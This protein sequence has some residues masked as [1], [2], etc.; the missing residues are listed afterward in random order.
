[1]SDFI[2]AREYLDANDVVI[3]NCDYQCNVLVMDDANFNNYRRGGRF[4]YYGGHYK[5]LPARISV[6]HSDHWN[7]VID[8]G[9]GRATIRYNI[10][11]LRH[12]A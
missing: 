9:G 7:T 11:Y 2:H 6:P 8:L 5:R 4:Q 3:V 12:S 1:M 10:E